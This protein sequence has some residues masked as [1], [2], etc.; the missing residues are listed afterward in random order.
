MMSGWRRCSCSGRRSARGEVVFDGPAAGLTAGVLTRIYG[1]ED[2]TQ[3]AAAA[4][5]DDSLVAETER[6]IV[7]GAA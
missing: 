1:E 6:R 4:D 2:W 7:A 5:E 3:T